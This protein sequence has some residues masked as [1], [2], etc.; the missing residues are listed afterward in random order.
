MLNLITYFAKIGDPCDLPGSSGSFFGLPHWWEYMGKGVRDGLNQCT[1]RFNDLSDIFPIGLAV[2]DI[3]L[4]VAGFLA[5]ISIIIAGVEY[6]IAVGNPEK[7]TS[8]RKRAINSLVGLGI[9]LVATAT[10]SF[11]GRSL[12]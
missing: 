1:P 10:V 9:A 3:L 6:I 12:I 7:I 11:I 5:V 8:A 2:L 4:R